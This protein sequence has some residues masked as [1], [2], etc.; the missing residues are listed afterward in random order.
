MNGPQAPL[1]LA[2]HRVIIGIELSLTAHDQPV[3]PIFKDEYPHAIA[4]PVRR[5]SFLI[6]AIVAL[7]IF[8]AAPADG[9]EIAPER[10]GSEIAR[11]GFGGG[12]RLIGGDEAERDVGAFERVLR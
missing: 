1:A 8:L 5:Q 11:I 6:E 9:I 10:A 12:E 2:G 4:R 7:V 3:L